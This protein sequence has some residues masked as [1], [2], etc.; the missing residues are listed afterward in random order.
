MRS[1]RLSRLLLLAI[2]PIFS[3]VSWAQEQGS[4]NLTQITGRKE[5]RGTFTDKVVRKTFSDQL[6]P[7]LY[8]LTYLSESSPAVVTVQTEDGQLIGRSAPTAPLATVLS[9]RGR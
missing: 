7:G 6:V 1:T 2:I 3:H 8:R 4:S 9:G 5:L